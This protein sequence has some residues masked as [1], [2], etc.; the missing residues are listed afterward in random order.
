MRSKFS[1][2]MLG[3]ALSLCILAPVAAQTYTVR[4]GDTL[5]RIA[6]RFGI[7]VAALRAEN[8]ISGNL[9]LVGQRLEIP[10]ANATPFRNYTVAGG[11]TLTA[12]ARRFN[13]T[14]VGIRA[15]NGISGNLIV[16]GQRL[17]IPVGTAPAPT[18]SPTTPAT[19]PSNLTNLGIPNHPANRKLAAMSHTQTELEILAR[20]VKGEASSLVTW[21]G[22]VAVAA[23]VLNRVRHRRFPNSIRG[24]AHQRLQF[25]SYNANVRNRL[26]WGKIPSYAWRAA[27]AALA[28]ADPTGGCTHYYNPYLVRPSWANRL[29]FVRRIERPG[30]GRLTGHDFYGYRQNLTWS[31]GMTGALAGN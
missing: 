30:Y 10:S 3:V 25:S 11:D 15:A 23:V 12:I 8:G 21:E 17:R 4:S 16:V 28:G 1:Q 24:V 2:S 27:R 20:I 7:S 18:S 22:Q 13:S 5:S 19:P 9:I 14:V 29:R 6:T 26:Y 31:P